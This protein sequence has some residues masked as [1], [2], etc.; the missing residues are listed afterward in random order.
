MRD[1]LK[2]TKI[3]IEQLPTGHDE[4]VDQAMSSWWANIRKSGGLRLTEI[5]HQIFKMLDLQS[6]QLEIDPTKFDR[7]IL[8]KLD[9]KLQ[10]PYYLV[11]EKGIPKKLILFGS[12]EA[13]LANLYGNLEKFLDNYS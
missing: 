3:V 2:L 10:M 6:Y 12:K 11:V 4:T 7:K 8:L 13:M 1:K 5:G 9:R